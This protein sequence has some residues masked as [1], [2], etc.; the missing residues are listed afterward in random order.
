[1]SLRPSVNPAGIIDIKTFCENRGIDATSVPGIGR[2]LYYSEEALIETW[3]K[4][5]EKQEEI[6][7][8]PSLLAKLCAQTEKGL[9]ANQ[10]RGGRS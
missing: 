4:Y 2:C 6:R 7:Q 1:M 3:E 5:E 10:S 9:V 8:Y